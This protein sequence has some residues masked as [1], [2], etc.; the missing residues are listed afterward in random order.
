MYYIIFLIGIILSFINDKKRV[1]FKIY[2]LLLI[3]FACLRYGVG[4]D[5]FAYEY[6]YNRLNPSVINEF[7]YGLDNQ[8]LLFRLLGSFLK[9]IGFSYQQYLMFIAI[10]N[11][12]FISKIANKYS[13]NPTMSMLI[14]YSFYYLVWTFS[15]LRQGLTISIGMYYLLNCIEKKQTIKLISI[16]LLLSFI[17][18]S[19]I[20][21][22]PFYFLSQPKI[23]K[24]ELLYWSIVGIL[25]SLLPIGNILMHVSWLPF[26]DRLIPYIKPTTMLNRILDFQSIAR[27]VFLFIALLYYEPYSNRDE[28]SK[29]IINIY[30]VGLILYFVFKFSELTAARLSIYGKL[31][32]MIILPNIYY[33]YKDKVDKFIFLGLLL[34]LCSLYLFKELR[35]LERQTDLQNPMKII[36]PYTNIYNKDRFTF[37]KKYLFIIE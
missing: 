31:L 4:A 36:V 37:N 18:K 26:I 8:E 14:Y 22:I 29:V 9:G 30:I 1:S 7:K 25:I 20:I 34:V 15:G 13:K 28:M 35:T 27:L 33:A 6:L 21:L 32:D 12:F 2:V 10:I 23:G 19:A 3:A 17:H 5:Y 24:K 16:S 11:I